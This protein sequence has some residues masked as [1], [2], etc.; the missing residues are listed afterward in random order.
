MTLVCDR[1]GYA[2]GVRRVLLMVDGKSLRGLKMCGNC[3]D[4]V[5]I[6]MQAPVPT[7]ATPNYDVQITPGTYTAEVAWPA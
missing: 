3:L 2:T 4:R 6:V 1:C 5:T 7:H